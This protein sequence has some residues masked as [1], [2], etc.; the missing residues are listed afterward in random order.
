MET[1]HDQI[2]RISTKY[3]DQ[4]AVITKNIS[5]TYNKLKKDSDTLASNLILRG[6]KVGDRV[7]LISKNNYESIVSIVGV[8]KAGGTIV[9][10]NPK[11]PLHSIND[12]INDCIPKF[13][14]MDIKRE[15]VI[16]REI[17][18]AFLI[19][20][21]NSFDGYTSFETLLNGNQDKPNV[22]VKDYE[23][24]ALIYTSGSTGKPKGIISSHSNI[25]F[26]TQAINKFLRHNKQ[27]RILSFLPIS[28]DY[29]F[30]QIFLTLTTGATLYLRDS[31]LFL[32]ELEKIIRENN[33]T[34]LPTMRS[35]LSAFLANHSVQFKS[36]RYL[37]TTGDPIP[38]NLIQISKE[39]FP[40]ASFY[41][42]YGLTECKRVSFLK[43]EYI[44]TKI[45]SVGLPLDGVKCHLLNEN[46]EKCNPY[47]EG[48]LYVEGPNLCKGYW[49]DEVKTKET[50][51]IKDN[52]RMLK[53]GDIF[54]KDED[55]FLYYVRRKDNLVKVNGYRVNTSEIENILLKKIFFA[56]ELVVVPISDKVKVN[57]LGLLI[58]I[59]TNYILSD[60]L[61]DYLNDV[62][63]E[64]LEPWKR[65]DIIKTV[66]DEVP[67]TNSGKID[68]KKVIEILVQKESIENV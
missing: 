60:E 47:E 58:K 40:N 18:E 4:L 63:L 31:N 43:P 12:I 26:C 51:I 66:Y 57:K 62:I 25:V 64:E 50:F 37:T 9:C 20:A 65:P 36:L 32:L 15:I 59:K 8:F 11:T 53:T 30:Y 52:N 33:I 56:N 44:H 68:R 39:V 35:M 7:L 24:A 22:E 23:N 49:G 14:V 67:L 55:G 1:I 21:S 6:I 38:S 46:G 48:E 54:Y 16:R 27:D 13:I 29:G 10:I 17:Q 45:N 28:F 3:P 42:N 41:I 34:G 19:G 61:M 2:D 5:V